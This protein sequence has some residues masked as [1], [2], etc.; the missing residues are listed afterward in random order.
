MET[1]MASTIQSK[2]NAM[3]QQLGSTPISLS[4]LCI[5]KSIKKWQS[6]NHC[7]VHIYELMHK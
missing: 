4:C 5:S 3:V 2:L 6:L 7:K 1:P